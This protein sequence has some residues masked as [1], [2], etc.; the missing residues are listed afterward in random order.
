MKNFETQMLG[1]VATLFMNWRFRNL[2]S[3]VSVEKKISTQL[4]NTSPI[5]L[6]KKLVG[7]PENSATIFILLINLISRD[8]RLWQQV[9]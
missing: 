4:I 9:V 3:N 7:K 2:A 6:R 5:V 8:I 1:C